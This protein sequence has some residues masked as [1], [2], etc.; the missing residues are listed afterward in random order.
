MTYMDDDMIM[1]DCIHLIIDKAMTY[2]DN[3]NDRLHSFN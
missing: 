3:D 2:N 1:I